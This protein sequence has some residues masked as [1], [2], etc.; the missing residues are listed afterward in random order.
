[1]TIKECLLDNSKECNDCGECEICDLDPNKICDNCCRCLGDADYS[2][3]KVE[4][5]IMP[6]KI[7][8]KRKK[9]KK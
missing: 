4:K 8:F 5:I 9:I 7:L 6:E 3:I 1:M 2:A